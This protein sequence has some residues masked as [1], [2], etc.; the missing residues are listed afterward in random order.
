MY[1]LLT[2]LVEMYPDHVRII[3]RHFPLSNIHDKAQLAAEATEAAAAQGDFWALHDAIYENQV[4]WAQLSVDEAKTFL[5]ELAAEVGLDDVAM[6]DALD[7]KTYESRVLTFATEARNL[8]L[9]GTPALIVDGQLIQGGTPEL[10]VWVQYI[11]GQIEFSEQFGNIPSYDAPDDMEVDVAAVYR[12]TVTMESG[13]QFVMELYPEFAPQTVNSFLFLNSEGWFDGV[14]FHRV[15]PG[16]VAQT[17]DPTGSGRGGPGYSIINEISELSHDDKGVVA[18]AN[19]GPD[20]NGSQWYITL[21]PTTQL[22]GSYTV[23]GKV[24]EGMEVVEAIS[25][26]DPADPN[27]PLGDAIESITIVK[28]TATTGE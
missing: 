20:T 23:F 28:D 1:P 16:F 17:G 4:A 24:V 25:P 2:S 26:R 15:I 13:D 8:G 10:A 5:V 27:A 7:N 18:M 3:Y 22:D 9:P 19:S 12:A 11:D 21:A 6:Q 14:T